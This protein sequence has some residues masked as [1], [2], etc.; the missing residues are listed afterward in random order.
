MGQVGETCTSFIKIIQVSSTSHS[1]CV[2]ARLDFA[3]GSSIDM[4]SVRVTCLAKQVS[5]WNHK[6]IIC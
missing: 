2:A 6:K 5:M 3:M 1:T 4:H